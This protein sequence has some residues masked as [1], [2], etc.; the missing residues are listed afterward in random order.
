MP[1]PLDH[2]GEI[3]WTILSGRD[4]E[5]ECDAFLNAVVEQL[6]REQA[7]D[8]LVTGNRVAFKGGMFRLVNNWNRLVSISS[9]YI[10][11]VPANGRVVVTYYLSYR[12]LLIFASV[13]V[14][15]MG[16]VLSGDNSSPVEVKLAIVVFGWLWL[17]GINFLIS[18]GRFP[19]L[20]D[21][22]MESRALPPENRV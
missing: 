14:L 15:L 9:G 21:R 5:W 10:E 16:L 8:I 7:N 3:S 2:R 13:G 11:A 17:F 20:I 22:A 1:F 6:E 12:Q 18:V 19:G 4:P